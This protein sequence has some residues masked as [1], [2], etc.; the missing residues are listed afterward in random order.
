MRGRDVRAALIAVGLLAA[1]TASGACDDDPGRP[2]F[3]YM[4]DMVGSLAYDSFDPNPNTPDGRTLMKPPAGTI[5]RGYQPV[6]FGPGPQEAVR[7]GRELTNPLPDSEAVRARGEMAFLSW[8]RSGW[9]DGRACWRTRSASRP[10]AQENTISGHA[11]EE[12]L[13]QRCLAVRVDM[14]LQPA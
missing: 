10:F 11:V 9:G 13:D 3:E 1:A 14:R 8:S 12:G 7:A 5:P 2:N 6:H 4:P